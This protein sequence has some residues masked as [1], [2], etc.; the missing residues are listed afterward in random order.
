MGCDRRALRDAGLDLTSNPRPSD[1]DR[2]SRPARVL[3]SE[4]SLNPII[5]NSTGWP[6]ASWLIT[7]GLWLTQHSLL[8]YVADEIR[9]SFNRLVEERQ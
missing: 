3:R 6:F 2:L 9:P 7:P 5:D 4:R 1:L 8:C